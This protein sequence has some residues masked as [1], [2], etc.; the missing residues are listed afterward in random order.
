VDGG[1]DETASGSRLAENEHRARSYYHYHHTIEIEEAEYN[2]LRRA[3]NLSTSIAARR[4][5]S[6]QPHR[7]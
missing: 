6:A 2:L 7:R 5:S 3:R 4:H 1:S